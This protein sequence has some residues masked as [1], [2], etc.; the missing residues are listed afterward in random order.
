MKNGEIHEK[1]ITVK[2]KGTLL[3]RKERDVTQIYMI[4]SPGLVQT[5]SVAFHQRVR[6]EL[7]RFR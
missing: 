3:N 7:H 1:L 4:H 6:S 2:S 5:L